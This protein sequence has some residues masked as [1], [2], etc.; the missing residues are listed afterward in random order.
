MELNCSLST[1]S[2]PQDSASL[3]HT[4]LLVAMP[5]ITVGTRKRDTIRTVMPDSELTTMALA[6][7]S[8]AMQ[9]VAW[10]MASERFLI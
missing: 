6:P 10:E 7:M 1:G 5:M 4:A 8:M 9:Q 2:T 3:Y